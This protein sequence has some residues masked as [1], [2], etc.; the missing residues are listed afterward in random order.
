V[1]PALSSTCTALRIRNF[2]PDQCGGSASCPLGSR[3]IA[4]ISSGELL[5]AA[6]NSYGPASTWQA[7]SLIENASRIAG[8]APT[9][10]VHQPPIHRHQGII[11]TFY[12]DA[13]LMLRERGCPSASDSKA[14]YAGASA[15]SGASHVD[16]GRS[17]NE[18]QSLRCFRQRRVRRHSA[19]TAADGAGRHVSRARLTGLARYASPAD[20]LDD[21]RCHVASSQCRA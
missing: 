3:P 17:F 19:A 6:G 14:Q 7:L 20:R 10:A 1:C 4:F 16:G 12:G 2:P 5:C 15:P 21:D 9:R 18:A 8:H 13:P 11:D